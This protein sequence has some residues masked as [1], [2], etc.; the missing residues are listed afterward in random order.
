[1]PLTTASVRLLTSSFWKMA[2]R[3]FLIVLTKQSI[4]AAISLFD[5]PLP[6][7][8]SARISVFVSATGEVE[9]VIWRSPAINFHTC[10]ESSRR[11]QRAH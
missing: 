1:M 2:L 8:T 4:L 7:N 5:K 11:W 10:Q 6:K 3:W 9:P